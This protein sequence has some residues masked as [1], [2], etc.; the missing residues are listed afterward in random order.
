MFVYRPSA[1]CSLVLLFSNTGHFSLVY[2]IVFTVVHFGVD[3]TSY[4]ISI[5]SYSVLQLVVDSSH[6]CG[7]C[8]GSPLT[9]DV[10]MVCGS[11]YLCEF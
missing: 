9:F 4:R 7:W 3:F 10:I 6:G 11:F 8:A 5:L 1:D 2:L